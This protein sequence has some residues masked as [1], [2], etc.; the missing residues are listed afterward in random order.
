MPVHLP[1]GMPWAKLTT[2]SAVQGL[3]QLVVGA[4]YQIFASRSAGPEQVMIEK[5]GSG[6]IFPSLMSSREA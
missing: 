6:R 5:D 3:E 1:V 2:A 4:L